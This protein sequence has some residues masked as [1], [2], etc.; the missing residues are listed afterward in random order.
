M[1]AHYTDYEAALIYL[2]AVKR[3]LA[4]PSYKLRRELTDCPELAFVHRRHSTGSIAMRWT[5]F[6]TAVSPGLKPTRGAKLRQIR[7]I[8]KDLEAVTGFSLRK[9]LVSS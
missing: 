1:T 9:D 4:P 2:A 3:N 6:R 8:V 7:R 5:D